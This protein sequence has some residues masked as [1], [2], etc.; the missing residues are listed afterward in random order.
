MAQVY[1]ATASRRVLSAS[2]LKGDKVVN[3]QGEDLGKIED[4]MIDLER[5]RIAYAVLSFGGFLGM[6][7]KLFAIPWDAFTVD[8][9]QKR[10]VLNAD[11]ELLKKAPG[12]DKNNWPDMTNSAWGAELYGYYGYRPY[13]D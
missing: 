8:T 13:W 9:A 10:L 5:G 4:L 2:T 1:P 7:D 12:F 3:L 6:G 11:K